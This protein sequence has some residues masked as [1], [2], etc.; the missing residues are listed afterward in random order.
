MHDCQEIIEENKLLIS[1]LAEAEKTI[2]KLE[3]E[4]KESYTN[5]K[6]KELELC[7]DKLVSIVDQNTKDINYFKNK[8]NINNRL[9]LIKKETGWY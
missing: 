2:K 8:E 7:I 4:F 1:Q 6:I 3:N 9:S 5:T